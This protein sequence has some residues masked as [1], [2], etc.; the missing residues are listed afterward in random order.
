MLHVPTYKATKAI[1]S[2]AKWNRKQVRN[3]DA[4]LRST[5]VLC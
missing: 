4:V 2:T 3:S 5:N 1:L